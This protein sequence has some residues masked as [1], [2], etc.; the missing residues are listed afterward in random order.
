MAGWWA[1]VHA[2]FGVTVI[3]ELGF[4]YGG[5]SHDFGLVLSPDVGMS[6]VAR[7]TAG[8]G[9]ELPTA[10][11]MSGG[12]KSVASFG[13]QL[14][15]Y[16]A[17][18]EPSNF[19]PVFPSEDLYPSNSLFPTPRSQSPGFG[20]SLVPEVGFGSAVRYGREFE[21]VLSPMV[22]MAATERYSSGFDLEVTPQVGMSAVEHYAR[23]FNLSLTPTVGMDGVGVNGVTPVAFDAA[24][25]VNF[26]T[27]DYTYDHTASAGSSVVVAV[28]V[29]GN[30]TVNGVT[31]GGAA[32]TPKGSVYLNNTATQGALWFYFIDD[33][34]GGAQTVAIDKNGFSW[35]RSVALSY[36]N[37][38][39]CS[40]LV[41]AY[42]SGTSVSQAATNV[43]G[44]MVVQAMGIVN[45][46]VI[47]PSGG[48]VR[49]NASNTGGSIAASDSSSSSVTFT[50]TIAAS[51]TW[52][53]AYV[54]LSPE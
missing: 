31:Y 44:G 41:G 6:G 27:A 48:T 30:N 49:A 20:V 13:L 19:T 39:S 8:F 38:G 50:A 53:S 16:I 5:P 54:V 42:G 12:G 18:R 33:V 47:T 10:I 25:S 45:N 34:A 52:A 24:S 7:N 29:A 9:L 17:M 1:E 4:V 37:V 11:G 32:M 36:R 43:P 15:P 2:H 46:S 35:S 51:N 26:S 21:L 28:L 22:G 23:E 3:P 40:S 14:N